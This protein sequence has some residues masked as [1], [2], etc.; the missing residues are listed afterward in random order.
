MIDE[1]EV[2]ADDA[3]S[4]HEDFDKTTLKSACSNLG[5]PTS[6]KKDEL[7]A[8]LIEAGMN[9]ISGIN[10]LAQIEIPEKEEVPA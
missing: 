3:L 8:R 6:G 5:L 10:Q 9:S 1:P 2:P 7:L 4:G